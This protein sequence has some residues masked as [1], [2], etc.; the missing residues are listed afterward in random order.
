MLRQLGKNK[1]VLEIGSSSYE[2]YR[3]FL[4]SSDYKS[5]DIVKHDSV[6]IVGDIHTL[7]WESSY[8]EIIL[9]IE[10]LEHLYD[11]KTAIQ[12][13]F[14]LLKPGGV[15]IFSTRF[16]FPY[17]P[18][19][20]DYYRFTKDSLENLFESFTYVQIQHHGNGMQVFWQMITYKFPLLMYPLKL[21]NPLV[22]KLESK[23]TIYPSGF[24]VKAI[25]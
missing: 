7:D 20:K 5:L 19:E 23:N 12:Q 15:C 6:D 14:R 10:I 1:S 3:Q 2:V 17:H 9:G 18:C 13:V 11:P 16:M 24:I 25:K 21:L 8:F 22:A 4:T